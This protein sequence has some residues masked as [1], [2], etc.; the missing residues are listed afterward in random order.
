MIVELLDDIFHPPGF[1][2]LNALIQVCFY[3]D[4]HR[5]K[6]NFS[7]IK[8][9]DGFQQLTQGDKEV[10]EQQFN[11]QV[12][13]VEETARIKVSQTV[14]NN[15]FTLSEA[16]RYLSQPSQIILENNLN[17]GYFIETIINH[18][19][20]DKVL[21]KH[22]KNGWLKF[23]NA[24][25]CDNVDNFI[26]GEAK[27]YNGLPKNNYLYLRCIVILDSDKQ[28]PTQPLKS[29]YNTLIDKY[30]I[31][32]IYVHIL[33]KRSME[34]Y[35]PT[36]VYP[37]LEAKI[38]KKFIEAFMSLNPQ[39][40]DFYNIQRGFDGKS[41]NDLSIEV[42]SLYE[43]VSDTNYEILKNGCGLGNFK[44]EYPKFMEHHQVYKETL[45]RR[46]NHQV[47]PDELEVIIEEI[48]KLI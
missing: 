27:S 48:R 20:A 25:G 17:D 30:S 22:I 33:E 26:E 43:D 35:L 2:D 19:D 1:N 34:N 23:A 42:A 32:G 29:Q 28:Y 3:N 41:R 44:S 15:Y 31:L 18:L 10:L 4:R 38:S 21:Q 46:T 36:E 39:Q 12:Q 9:S 37:Y 24:G 16:N 6:T 47:S 7:R 11:A 14:N 8:N 13:G 45:L 5:V 40:I